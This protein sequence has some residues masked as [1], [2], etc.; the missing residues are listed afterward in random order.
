MPDRCRGWM[1]T[2]IAVCGVAAGAHAFAQTSALKI[3][4]VY[5]GS[6]TDG[7]STYNADFVV[8]F[9]SG[10][11]AAALDGTSLQ[12]S[13]ANGVTWT[14]LNLPDVQLA[15]GRFY[16]VRMGPIRNGLN[17]LPTPDLVWGTSP[18][19]SVTAAKLA[20]VNWI[21]NA[22]GGPT[23]MGCIDNAINPIIDV[24]S[25]GLPTGSNF[26]TQVSAM[27]D[28]LSTTTWA[29]R[30]DQTSGGFT[31]PQD[32][33]NTGADFIVG[34]STAPRNS[35]T[36]AAPCSVASGSDLGVALVPNATQID[37]G[38]AVS[39]TATIT[40]FGPSPATG[41]TV[42]IALPASGVSVNAGASTPGFM[43]VGNA[44]SWTFAGALASGSTRQF[45]VALSTSAHATFVAT[46]SLTAASPS[47]P[48]ASNNTSV[49]DS[50]LV[51][52]PAQA[53]LFAGV[54]TPTTALKRVDI[55]TGAS[56]DFSLGLSYQGLA[57]DDSRQVFWGTDG[58]DLYYVPYYV[59]TPI[60]VGAIRP[61]GTGTGFQLVSGLAAGN[62]LIYAN[63]DENGGSS[64]KGLY[65]LDARTAASTQAYLWD[66]DAPQP[67]SPNL[68]F[69]GIDFNPLDG[70]VYGW[71]RSTVGF[72]AGDGVGL[73]AIDVAGRTIAKVPGS[74]PAASYPGY[75]NGDIDGLA[76]GEG[77]AYYVIDQPGEIAVFDLASGAFLPRLPSPF[78]SSLT[79]AGAAFTSLIASP[80]SGINLGV[81]LTGPATV[82]TSNPSAVS[83]MLKVTNFGPLA[84]GASSLVFPLPAGLAL[85]SAPGGV[86][87]PTSVTYGVPALLLGASQTYTLS[88]VA[89]SG[90]YT[91]GP[92]TV[93]GGGSE[94]AA[95]NNTSQTV[96]TEVVEQADLSVSGGVSCSS[97]GGPGQA[98]YV[99][100]NT[101]AATAQA[102]S[103]SVFLPPEF[104]FTGSTPAGTSAGG[105]LTIA[106]GAI[107]PGAAV[108]VTITGL[109]T[110]GSS[111]APFVSTATNEV[112]FTN[113][114]VTSTYSLLPQAFTPANVE[115]LLTT[116]PAGGAKRILPPAASLPAGA[117]GGAVLTSTGAGDAGF[118][119][120]FFSPN[121]QRWIAS[122]VASTGRSILLAG[123]V[124]PFSAQVIAEQGVTA[125][126]G[127]EVLDSAIDANM[128]ITD[129]G[130]FVFSAETD[131]NS[132]EVDKVV[133]RGQVGVAGFTILAR[134]GD[135]IAGPF[136]A[137]STAV[138]GSTL[139]AYGI[140]P[141][142][143]VVL[144]TAMRPSSIV[145]GMPVTS[146]TDG[147]ILETSGAGFTL[148]A[149]EGNA[150][151]VAGRPYLNIPSPVA[152]PGAGVLG[153]SDVFFLA[154]LTGSTSD[155][156]VA[157]Y[158]NTVSVREGDTLGGFTLV[159]PTFATLSTA[160]DRLVYGASPAQG[161][162]DFVARNGQLLARTGGPVFAGSALTWADDIDAGTFLGLAGNGAGQVVVAGAIG[163]GGDAASNTV[164]ISP[165]A[166]AILVRENQAIDLDGD[167]V[168]DDGVFLG[169]I[170]ADRLS[171]TPDGWVWFVARLR[172]NCTGSP[173]G[174]GVYPDV[175]SVLARVRV[176][177]ASVVC[178]R[179]V[180][181]AVLASAGACTAPAGVGVRTL[182][183]SASSCDGQSAVNSGC[184]YADFNKSGVK[185]VADIFA[186]LSAW[187]ANSPFSDVGGD[188]TGT[189][190]VSDIFQFLSAW[191]V[192]CG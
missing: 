138:F 128:G 117:F 75:A 48:Q 125:L 11:V 79:G 81:D 161:N 53:K 150:S 120:P 115:V 148:V 41:F 17:P 44:V 73:Y 36:A 171:I 143:A 12:Y 192:G 144:Y 9:N 146:L 58:F 46:A 152:G 163:T 126:G 30:R 13:G 131:A 28:N 8:L 40:N 135:T 139:G 110:G 10:P 112:D 47:D 74:V 140:R 85:V 136:P 32:T 35:G 173:D 170:R 165:T 100:A 108:A 87:G 31:C 172:D 93:S 3:Y 1:R 160:G 34:S 102:S 62:G 51:Y 27:S 42:S 88:F 180:T 86:V 174:S 67:G 95:W 70:K 111:I 145:G 103:L 6:G 5:G 43:Q 45:T 168:F 154:S 158:N 59:P 49:A 23:F 80:P 24:V 156:G 71:Q 184:C 84:A 26:C 15:P 114:G 96:T 76:V 29:T 50:V 113:N 90:T 77:R 52:N 18:N 39:Y 190:D 141:S 132:S 64:P 142:G 155:D 37:L 20:L 124:S 60:R 14:G 127:G 56:R 82:R 89:N 183:A 167:G 119:R 63:D 94:L 99:V 188:G 33:D 121:G 55:V 181:C 182:G 21:N 4:Q 122:V 104:G 179:G 185:D 177:A 186:F 166:S 105:Q 19:I 157:V 25:Y 78:T 22:S 69:D 91:V 118:S 92:A 189:R 109:P 98:S 57:A 129:A 16:L 7:V 191:F 178:C 187:F 175:S 153:A 147:V 38:G 130:Q 65:T 159:A 106:L 61:D 134:E 97:V 169:T 54:S 83:Y 66:I 107:A 162:T 176:P 137:G 2:L 151:P 101:G 72:P 164:L 116:H 149:R 123:T 68:A 133:L